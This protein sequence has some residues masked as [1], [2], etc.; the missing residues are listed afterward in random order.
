M[1]I[2]VLADIAVFPW[3]LS[4]ESHYEAK[5]TLAYLGGHCPMLPPPQ[6][7]NGA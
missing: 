5:G 6:K 2:T 4:V 1:C 7:K 3:Q